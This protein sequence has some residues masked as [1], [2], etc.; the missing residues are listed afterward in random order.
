MVHVLTVPLQAA[1][2]SLHGFLLKKVIPLQAWPF[3]VL[4]VKHENI[5]SD[6]KE[7]ACM[8]THVI[9]CFGGSGQSAKHIVESSNEYV[10]KQ[11]LY[12]LTEA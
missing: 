3:N 12:K 8:P 5:L 1:L 6:V 4:K 2:L 11:D 10:Y 9:K 7:I